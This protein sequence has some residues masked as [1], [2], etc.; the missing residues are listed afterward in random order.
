MYTISVDPL[1]HDKAILASSN[2]RGSK[3]WEKV[4]L[5]KENKILFEHLLHG[6]V[7]KSKNDTVPA[8][9]KFTVV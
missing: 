9:K 2:V 8:L 6:R 3:T 1:Y 4:I 7:Y 5:L